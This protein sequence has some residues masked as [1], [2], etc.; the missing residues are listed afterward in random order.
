MQVSAETENFDFLDQVFL[1]RI[2]PVLNRKSE[3][4]HYILHIQVCLGAKFYFGGTIL[5]FRTNLA[6]KG[7]SKNIGEIQCSFAPDYHVPSLTFTAFF[8]KAQ[9]HYYFNDSSPK[10]RRDNNSELVVFL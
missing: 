7:I 1:K 4:H 6:Q 2:F 8:G 3:H 10:G 9:Y 5:N